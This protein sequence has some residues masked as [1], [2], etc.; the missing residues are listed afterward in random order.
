MKNQ[1]GFTLVEL[2]VVIVI[3]GIITALALPEVGQLQAR[4]RNKKFEAY[5]NSLESAGKLYTDSYS[6]DMFGME[7]NGCYDIPYSE[8]KGK[9]LIKDYEV[10]GISCNHEKTFVQ[11]RKENNKYS[12]G[13]S[14]YCTKNGNVTYNSTLTSC[15]ANN[16][17]TTDIPQIKIS[18]K[19][20][21]SF[22]GDWSAS[23]D[24]TIEVKAVDGL[25]D[26]ITI[27]YGWSTDPNTPPTEM[28][29][30]N[31]RNDYGTPNAT[32]TFEKS[33]LNGEYYLFVDGDDVIDTG[34]RF[35]LDKW[36]T[37][38]KFDNTPP[39]V[40]VLNNP[41]DN[42]WTGIKYVNANSYVIGVTSS[43]TYSGV[44]YYQYRYPN[45]ENKWH[46]YENSAGNSYT[47]TP[48][49]NQR[50]ENVEIRAC[51]YANNCSGGA[52]S[53]IKID[54]ENPTVSIKLS[55]TPGNSGWYISD[56]GLT[57]IT[58]DTGGS[59]V[60]GYDLTTSTA[61][62]YK[63]VNKAT[64]TTAVAGVIWYGYV[65]DGA[66]NTASTKSP[67]FKVD[68]TAPILSFNLSGSTSTATC[69]DPDSGVVATTLQRPFLR[70]YIH[71]K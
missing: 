51:D 63:G 8:L 50:D 31:Y 29:T 44:A 56:V 26:N 64:Q 21:N 67:S 52:S 7:G 57:L 27:E 25:I 3:I 65:T 70:V 23:K 38:M 68:S 60:S 17:T 13:V 12:Y 24:I 39:A 32:M 47:T 41:K 22:S 5:S 36:S 71:M 40:P 9:S 37:V 59:G 4:N 6:D 35:A 53:R 14:L 46:T 55:G 42:I 19:N 18:Y 16:E 33:G 43:D 49:K 10:D 15:K 30:Y 28:T 2:L 69:A 62:T 66:G 58:N 34:G 48:F 11:V 1:K 45:S 61:T 54:M 20:K